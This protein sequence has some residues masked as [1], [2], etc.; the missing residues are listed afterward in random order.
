[1]YNRKIELGK[2]YRMCVGGDY[3]QG[4]FIMKLCGV[5]N[6]A[7]YMAIN[8][9]NWFLEG[10]FDSL[11]EAYERMVVDVV[12]QTSYDLLRNLKQGVRP[13]FKTHGGLCDFEMFVRDEVF[14]KFVECTY[15]YDL[16]DQEI[17]RLSK[18]FQSFEIVIEGLN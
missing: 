1:M 3:F 6:K 16:T 13:V 11:E 7:K 8:K 17:D 4:F 10:T 18:L 9:E 5:T 2:Q 14:D 12:E 15:F